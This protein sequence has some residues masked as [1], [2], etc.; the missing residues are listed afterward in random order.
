M[1]DE[2][3]EEPPLEG[4]LRNLHL[5]MPLDAEREGPLLVYHGLD[6]A[7]VRVSDRPQSIAEPPHAL[8]MP[9]ADLEFRHAVDSLEQR[10]PP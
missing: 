1:I 4:I 2:R 8:M 3:A 5:G 10:T 9:G 6:H 7:V